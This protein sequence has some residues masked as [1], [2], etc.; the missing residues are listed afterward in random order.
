MNFVERFNRMISFIEDNVKDDRNILT[1][2]Q[3]EFAMGNPSGL[4]SSFEFI[5]G[6][7]PK[8]YIN[9]RRL[10][11]ARAFI[12]E[13]ECTIEFAAEAF[14]YSSAE[15]FMNDFKTHFGCTVKKMDEERLA[16]EIEPLYLATILQKGG[17]KMQ[18]EAFSSKQKPMDCNGMNFEK[19][20]KIVSL[21]DYYD[22]DDLEFS[23][24]WE[25]T[26]EVDYSVDA[27]FSFGEDFFNH[28][29]YIRKRY[30]EVDR[31]NLSVVC[32]ELNRCVRS[33]LE[34]AMK[35]ESCNE[36][37]TWRDFRKIPQKYWEILKNNN[38]AFDYEEFPDLAIHIFKG[39][40]RKTTDFSCAED[41]FSF[42]EEY[43]DV[44]EG[45]EE[46]FGENNM[47]MYTTENIEEA[48]ADNEEY[49]EIED[50]YTEE[51]LGIWHEEKVDFEDDDF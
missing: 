26:K 8:Q 31:R 40:A 46:Y 48:M 14:G 9:R 25:L 13:E 32:M 19:I 4:A 15:R 11:K 47:K 22:F 30:P 29:D 3:K 37:G 51:F 5:T 24:I 42:I 27:I 23:A 34:I 50:T 12:A 38:R 18:L 17:E 44:D 10:I 28:K 16:I 35:I 7:R 21:R 43:G 1:S 2:F 41:V 20:T 45:L 36:L 49:A 39:I 33:G 6:M